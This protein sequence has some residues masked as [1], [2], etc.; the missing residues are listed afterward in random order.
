MFASAYPVNVIACAEQIQRCIYETQNCDT[1]GPSIGGG[2]LGGE[3]SF[4]RYN[5]MFKRLASTRLTS[6]F[7]VYGGAALLAQ[8]HCIGGI[9]APLPDDQW[10]LEFKNVFKAR[11]ISMQRM[12]LDMVTGPSNPIYAP[13]WAPPTAEDS[14]MCENQIVVHDDYT[15]F[16]ML[17]I[18]L[19]LGL[20]FIIVGLDLFLEFT[21]PQ[22]QRP[23]AKEWQA[24]SM[25][26][27]HRVVLSRHEETMGRSPVSWAWVDKDCP[28]AERQASFGRVFN[29]E[30]THNQQRTMATQTEQWTITGGEEER[31]RDADTISVKSA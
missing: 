24:L 13:F 9:C 12:S 14:W 2:I 10:T 1:L 22:G 20:G 29:A 4:G 17:A 31:G 28:V 21:L 6:L 16:S 23:R 15:S 3:G 19:I 5:S 8:S 7:N 26:Q 30:A 27:L 18:I 11:L 25:L